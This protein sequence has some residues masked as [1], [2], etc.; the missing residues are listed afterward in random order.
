V[1][2][3]AVLRFSVAAARKIDT[4][5]MASCRSRSFSSSGQGVFRKLTTDPNYFLLADWLL[6][7]AAWASVSPTAGWPL[8][9]AG[10][11]LF[12]NHEPVGGGPSD[13]EAVRRRFA[14]HDLTSEQHHPDQKDCRAEPDH[15][16]CFPFGDIGSVSHG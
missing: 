8:N 16:G 10:P 6:I 7:S 1:R 5:L 13:H 2:I 14:A 12:S 4:P 11:L 15:D 3:L 9:I